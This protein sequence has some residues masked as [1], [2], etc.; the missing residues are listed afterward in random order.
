MKYD[1]YVAVVIV[2]GVVAGFSAVATDLYDKHYEVIESIKNIEM[3]ISVNI[4]L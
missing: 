4:K 1:F 2:A 3:T